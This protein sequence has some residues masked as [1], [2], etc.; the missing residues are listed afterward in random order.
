M[1]HLRSLIPLRRRCEARNGVVRFV[2]ALGGHAAGGPSARYA[3]ERYF[4][5][6]AQRDSLKRL[7][8]S[9]AMLMGRLTHE[10]LGAAWSQR[11]GA[12]ADRINAI[13]K[14]VFSSTMQVAAPWA[15]SLVV[16]GDVVEETRKLKSTSSGDLTIFGFGKLA[17]VLFAANLL[18][19]L[20][21]AVNPILVGRG[22]GFASQRSRR[23]MKLVSSETLPTGVVVLTYRP[24]AASAS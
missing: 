16:A 5:E 13:R 11:Q 10:A 6:D 21:M 8:I 17:G 4:D 20:R 18:D 22:D 14:Y 24:S 2:C 19:E 1:K 12:F 3:G 7:M 15:N 9:D 23:E